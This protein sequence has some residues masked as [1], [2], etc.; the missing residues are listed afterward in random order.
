MLAAVETEQIPFSPT[1]V[2]PPNVQTER[3]MPTENTSH[4]T[5]K[6]TVRPFPQI[7]NTFLRHYAVFI[8]KV[9]ISV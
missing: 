7:L 5:R 6:F 9:E 3:Q 1:S 4:I 2:S 8:K